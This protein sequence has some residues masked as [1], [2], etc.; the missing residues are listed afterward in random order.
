MWLLCELYGFVTIVTA[1]TLNPQ[2]GFSLEVMQN[3]AS[4]WIMW[5]I[6]LETTATLTQYTNVA[7]ALL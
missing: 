2:C 3:V 5:L 7:S 6:I 1:A 4:N